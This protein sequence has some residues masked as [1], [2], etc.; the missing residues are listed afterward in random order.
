VSLG[1]LIEL[2]RREIGCVGDTLEVWDER[3]INI[4]NG[5]PVNAEEELRD[6]L[7]FCEGEASRTYRMSL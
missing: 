1:N 4:A 2:I 5:I 3:R 6:R 7:A